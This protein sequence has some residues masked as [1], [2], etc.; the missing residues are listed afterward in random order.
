MKPKRSRWNPVAKHMEKYNK[1][2]TILH[3]KEKLKA[4]MDKYPKQSI[5]KELEEE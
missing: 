1:P 2:K 4:G 3:K 5:L